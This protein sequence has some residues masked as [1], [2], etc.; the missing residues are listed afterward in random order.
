MTSP[1]PEQIERTNA[2][3][4]RMIAKTH[5]FVKAQEVA[6]DIVNVVNV[7]CT[8]NGVQFR[9]LSQHIEN[10]NKLDIYAP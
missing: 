7:D 1:T 10:T 3:T 8:H 2:Q 4:L 6:Q 9:L 5:V